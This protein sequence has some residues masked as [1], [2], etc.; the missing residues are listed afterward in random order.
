MRE[1]LHRAGLTWRVTPDMMCV[2]DRAGKFVAVNPAWQATLGW[3]REQMVGQPYLDFLHPGDVD[4]SMAAF[5]VVL[6]GEPVLRFENRYRTNAGDY[7]W[8]SWVAVPEGDEFFCT[9]RDVTEE[10]QHVETISEQRAEADLR[11]QFLAILGHDLRNPLAALKSG[12]ALLTRKAGDPEV[13]EI[14]SHMGERADRMLELIDNL[15]DFAKVRLG[16]ALGLH[17]KTTAN[18]STAISEIVGEVRSVS[19]NRTIELEFSG[20]GQVTCD[21]DRIK[22][23]L[24]NLLAN[25]V[26]HGDARRSA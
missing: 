12:V 25:A 16:D 3:S 8:F 1:E 14:C 18:I 21:V 2:L 22:Q 17:L 20:S 9:V 15:M 10:K 26:T 13:A 4:R 5:E 19:P 11:E 23:V 6:R 7:R 24:A